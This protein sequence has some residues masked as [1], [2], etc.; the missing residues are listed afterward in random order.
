MPKA[1]N[2]DTS[3][4]SCALPSVFGSFP[5]LS[6]ASL[7]RVSVLGFYIQRCDQCL[8]DCRRM[9]TSHPFGGAVGFDETNRRYH[10]FQYTV[11]SQLV[12]FLYY[13]VF[14]DCSCKENYLG[15]F[16]QLLF[17]R[18]CQVVLAEGRFAGVVST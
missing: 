8:R 6:F 16:E 15:F 11:S 10:H 5:G 12:S 13:V 4:T 2:T 1:W 17:A 14:F 18:R 7:L 3:C 9:G